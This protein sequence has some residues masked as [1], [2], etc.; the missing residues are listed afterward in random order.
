TP[1]LAGRLGA[2]SIIYNAAIGRP[3]EA[4]AVSKII[5]R[6]PCVRLID[7]VRAEHAGVNPTATC[8][9]TVGLQFPK[10]VHLRAVMRIAFA[11]DTEDD[12]IS[13]GLRIG[14]PTVDL[15]QYGFHVRLAALIFLIP[16]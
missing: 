2:G 12:S 7:F 13:I 3:D 15:G 10:S 11:I 14:G 1:G 6:T 4:P 5:F 9:G 8:G 16:P